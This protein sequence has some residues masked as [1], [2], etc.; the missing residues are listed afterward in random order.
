LS[1]ELRGV[2]ALEARDFKTAANFFRQGVNRTPGTNQLGRSLRH[3]L[4]TALF[5]SGDV[6]GAVKLFE[7]VIRLAPPNG[8]DESTAKAHYSLGVLS[9]SAGRSQDAIAH[10]TSAVAYSPTYVEAILALGEVLRMSGHSDA[11]LQR[12]EEVLRINQKSADARFGYAMALVRLKRYREARDW[13][14]DAIRL[15]P[16]RPDLAHAMARLLAAAPDDSV[17]D[18]PRA[19]AMVQQ[20]I[21]GQDTPELDETMAMAHAELGQFKEAATIQR[22]V[23]DAAARAGRTGSA[24]RLSANLR[25]YERGQPCR[26]PWSDDDPFLASGGRL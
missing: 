17:R 1:Y 2:R 9:A 4:G 14:T 6:P 13:L 24:R 21:K 25:L 23:M 8:L 26:T 16:D 20:L 3:K 5:L 22:G 11:A 10:L 15:H 12:Y 19:M 7:E 18:G